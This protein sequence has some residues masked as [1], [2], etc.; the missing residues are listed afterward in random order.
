MALVAGVDFG[1]LSVRVSIVSERGLLA[2]ALREYP[3]LGKREDPEYAIQSHDD[4]MRALASAA[5]EAVE[6]AHIPGDQVQALA[7][8][9]TGSSEK[10]SHVRPAEP[11]GRRIIEERRVP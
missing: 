3:L 7:V 5:R 9:T 4:R 10:C 8:G 11:V 6:N 2:T 1:T